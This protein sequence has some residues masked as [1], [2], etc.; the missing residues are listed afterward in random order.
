MGRDVEEIATAVF[1]RSE[2]K[3][4]EKAR[5]QGCR[6][7]GHEVCVGS[8]EE[9]WG[10][11]RTLR[12]AAAWRAV[13]NAVDVIHGLVRCFTWHKAQTSPPHSAVGLTGDT[14]AYLSEIARCAH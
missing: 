7:W 5:N 10:E 14:E 6:L 4:T 8:S 3:R 9:S 1:R 2:R 12:V 11:G 13:C